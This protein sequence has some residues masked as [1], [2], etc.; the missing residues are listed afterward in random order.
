MEAHPPRKFVLDRDVIAAGLRY[1][2][3]G[4]LL[5]W[6]ALA[7][8]SGAGAYFSLIDEPSILAKS[9]IVFAGLVAAGALELTRRLGRLFALQPLILVLIAGLATGFAL[10]WG[11]TVL[12]RPVMLDRP[13]ERVMVEGWITGIDPHESGARVR[14]R[15]HAISGWPLSRT[16]RLARMTQMRGEVL[17]PGRFVRCYGQLRPP[18]GAVL[19]GDYD[20]RLQAYFDGLGAVGYVL[21]S[22]RGGALG[23][24]P[25]ARTELELAALR[26]RMAMRVAGAAGERSGGFA[27]ALV[28]GDRSLMSEADREALRQSGLAHLL[29][30]SGLH[31]G[32]AGGLVYLFIWRALALWE[33]FALRVPVRRVAAAAAL[34][35]VTAYFLISG[36][37]VATQRAWIMS[38]VFFGAILA[39]RQAATARSLAL[40]MILVVMTRPESTVSPGFQMSFAATGV[41][42]AAFALWKRQAETGRGRERGL[43]SRL[44]AAAGSILLTSVAGSVATAPFGLFHF[45]RMSVLGIIANIAAM[46]VISLVVVPSA[47]GAL[48]L[49]PLGLQDYGLAIMGWG[50]GLVLDIAH[51]AGSASLELPWPPLPAI[52]AAGF[53]LAIAIFSIHEGRSRLL[54]IIISAASIGLWLSTPSPLAWLLPGGDAFV[55][56]A[57]A[58][59]RHLIPADSEPGLPPLRFADTQ[60]EDAD[61]SA[62]ATILADGAGS[63]RRLTPDSDC[64]GQTPEPA[65]WEIVDPSS[66]A[67]LAA[68][69]LATLQANAA[70]AILPGRKGYQLRVIPQRHRPWS[71]S[72][73]G[74]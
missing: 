25:A 43:L 14:L 57:D 11:H 17:S 35:A 69:S 56:E 12:R 6:F 37:S 13:L 53:G 18:P 19:P 50:L 15:V 46:P 1:E 67:C 54:P 68:L 7:L 70:V 39:D 64:G 31:L 2:A 63:L 21:G 42:I 3:A 4:Q 74:G 59:W 40:A 61:C 5:A 24:D 29:A 38:V 28:S 33:G 73:S 45:G 32:L 60:N 20:F 26:R 72:R 48:L 23:P 55:R 30:I 36:M 71:L 8:A 16:P 22:C 9:A 66:S 49:W 51:A 58:E 62:C 34:L 47:G 65:A 27:A 41:L 10:A 44:R 52:A